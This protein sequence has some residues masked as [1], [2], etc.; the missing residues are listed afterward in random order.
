MKNDFIATVSHEL[1]TPLSS[2]RVLVDTLLEGN[3]R[4]EEQA[5][6]YLRLTAKENERLS[7][8]IDNF[9]TFSRM[10]RDKKAFDIVEVSPVLIAEDAVEAIKT[11]FS[12]AGCDF[13]V[14]IEGD[15]PDVAG[16]HDAMV[17]VLVNLLDNA[18]KYT[19]DDKQISLRVYAEDDGVCFGVS[20]NGVGLTRRQVRKIFDRFYQV[21]RSLSRRAEGCGLGL[22]IVK[23]I[24]DAH[25]GKITVESR[26]GE[27]STFTVKLASRRAESVLKGK[28]K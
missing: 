11:K 13:E 18:C 4:D 16:D 17:T 2:M 10:E 25:K 27:G 12:S 22:S 7:R 9:L 15:L 1:K 8:M 28:M 19:H 24:V 23:F 6:E 5:D 21:D 14:E 20:D 3:V 26:P